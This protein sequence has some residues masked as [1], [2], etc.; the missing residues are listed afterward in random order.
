MVHILMNLPNSS[1]MTS[2]SA[3]SKPTSVG[4]IVTVFPMSFI[5][6]QLSVK[7]IQSMSI[8]LL[9]VFVWHFPK[10]NNAQQLCSNSQRQFTG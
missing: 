5:K 7:V 9:I 10:C 2:S 4:A 1:K 8:Y 3:T 6:L